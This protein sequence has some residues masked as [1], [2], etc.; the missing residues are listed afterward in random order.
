MMEQRRSERR[1][2]TADARV[3]HVNQGEAASVTDRAYAGGTIINIAIADLPPTGDSQ[4]LWGYLLLLAGSVTGL[5]LLR[6][7]KE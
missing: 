6:R 2:Q 4:N 5:I 3:G 1:A 7:R